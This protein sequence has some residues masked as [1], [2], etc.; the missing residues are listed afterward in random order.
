M[1]ARPT[2]LT[3]PA[4]QIDAI[5]AGQPAGL[6]L[7]PVGMR[8][9][10]VQGPASGS[11]IAEGCVIIEPC[12]DPVFDAAM[13]RAGARR[14]SE[15]NWR[16]DVRAGADAQVLRSVLGLID[17]SA[18][19][20]HDAALDRQR[21]RVSAPAR[22]RTLL[23]L[24]G[25]SE[26]VQADPTLLRVVSDAFEGVLAPAA[27]PLRHSRLVL[28]LTSPDALTLRACTSEDDACAP[29]AAGVDLHLWQNK[30]RKAPEALRI[31]EALRAR[32]ALLLDEHAQRGLYIEDQIDVPRLLADLDRT[33]LL[34]RRPH[35]PGQAHL[36]VG[37][38]IGRVP[39][40]ALRDRIPGQLTTVTVDARTAGE[41]VQR[42][43]AYGLRSLMDHQLADIC[44]MVAAAPAPDEVLRPFQAEGVGVHLATQIGYL[45]ACAVGLGK[46]VMTLRAWRADALARPGGPWRA[47]VVG[48]ASLRSQWE[49]QAQRFFPEAAACALERANLEGQIE[50]FEQRAGELPQIM[51]VSYDTLRTLLDG[52]ARH[53]RHVALDEAEILRN[54]SSLRTQALWR[55]RDLCQIA[56]ALTG[57]PIERDLD[58]LGMV[59]AWVRSDRTMFRAAARLSRSYD[60]TRPAEALRLHREIGPLLFRRDQSEIKSELPHTIHEVVIL[61]PTPQELALATAARTGLSQLIDQL[62]ERLQA[63]ENIPDTN[64]AQLAQ[65]RKELSSLRMGAISGITTARQAACDPEAVAASSS[66]VKVLLDA[67]GLIEPALRKGSTKR[68][69]V[70]E[71]VADLTSR[72]D[73]VL[74]FTEFQVTAKHMARDLKAR[75]VRVGLFTGSTSHKARDQAVVNFQAG[76]LDVLILTR[77]ARTGLDLFRANVVI[78]FDLPWVPS[79]IVQR[80]GRARRIGS[81]AEQLMIL[82]VVMAGTI[83]ERIAAVLLPR[84]AMMFAAL[85]QP[86]G[87]RIEDAEVAL[88]VAGLDKVETDHESTNLVQLDYARKLLRGD[89]DDGQSLAR[90][91]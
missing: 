79:W 87:T 82:T 10:W 51:I 25:A 41:I 88:A 57:T 20:A 66:A 17:G 16:V 1:A 24:L 45:N 40:V 2:A 29:G 65:A 3:L 70:V 64:K 18:C 77:T 73:A 72:G 7:A 83:E 23:D 26:L 63:L 21:F 52:P 22:V 32:R 42:A 90:A 9:R 13:Q 36:V 56:V 8:L 47:I 54:S 84:A 35:A 61:D 5:L 62:D 69:R 60:L 74:V 53:W 46:T 34:Y 89:L 14:I 55:L 58:D 38:G 31:D 80:I 49:R 6:H 59:L 86:R 39:G 81:T 67:Q 28:S 44:R 76:E 12:I 50:E 4:S 33:L 43:T 27:G 91:S 68:T 48:P 37:P 15:R 75:G 19:Y 78:N 11:Q 85:D 71:L 30:G